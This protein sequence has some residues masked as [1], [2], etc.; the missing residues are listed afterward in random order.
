MFKCYIC[1]DD[2]NKALWTVDIYFNEK[3]V[4]PDKKLYLNEKP[5]F[6][7]LMNLLQAI[8]DIQFGEMIG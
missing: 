5:D 7:T 2:N 3:S 6:N 1:Y 4:Y 8:Y